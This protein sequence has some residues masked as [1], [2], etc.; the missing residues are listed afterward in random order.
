MIIFFTRDWAGGLGSAPNPAILLLRRGGDPGGGFFFLCLSIFG[1][2]RRVPT[3]FMTQRKKR[4]REDGDRVAVGGGVGALPLAAKILRR[5]YTLRGEANLL[6]A[7]VGGSALLAARVACWTTGVPLD[8]CQHGV[9]VREV[10]LS[11]SPLGY[12]C[13]GGSSAKLF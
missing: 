6:A 1:T 5:V 11:T 13:I 10:S 3:A 8:P 4:P 7:G 9:E 2:G 12:S